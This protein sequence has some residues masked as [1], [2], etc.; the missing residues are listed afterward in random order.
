MRI[1]APLL[2]AKSAKVAKFGIPEASLRSLPLAKHHLTE[3]EGAR[4]L[5]Q[6]ARPVGVEALGLRQMQRQQLP[7]HDRGHRAK[8][9]GQPPASGSS[10]VASACARASSVVISSSAP[11]LWRSCARSSISSKAAPLGMIRIAGS[12]S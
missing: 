7:R 10:V 5:L 2:T 3:S 9:L 6:P 8:P 11:R 12:P 4:H 1:I